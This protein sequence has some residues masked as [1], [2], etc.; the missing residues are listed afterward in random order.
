LSPVVG[1]AE[2]NLELA[3]VMG[4]PPI[5]RT[6]GLLT[7]VW[8][9][10]L[11]AEVVRPR[12]PVPAGLETSLCPAR[13]ADSSRA[14]PAQMHCTKATGLAAVLVISGAAVV[15]RTKDCPTR[16]VLVG[17]LGRATLRRG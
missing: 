16:A 14:A 2:A 12:P 10:V 9:R 13:T 4:P 7:T 17:E 3:A 11:A 6:V 15:G 1:A 5:Q 8:E